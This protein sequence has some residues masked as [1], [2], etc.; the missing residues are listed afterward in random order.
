MFGREKPKT[1]TGRA[2]C[3]NCKEIITVEIP[4]GMSIEIYFSGDPIKCENCGCKNRCT[5]AEEDA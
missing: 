2:K 1:Y 5:G 3:W 4:Y